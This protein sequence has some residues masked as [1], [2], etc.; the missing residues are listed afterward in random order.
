MRE[1]IPR[2]PYGYRRITVRDG[3]KDRVKLA[4]V[5]GRTAGVVRM[6]SLWGG[7]LDQ[8]REALW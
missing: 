6:V 4:A 5:D 1:Q 8:A 3:K 2:A 7:P